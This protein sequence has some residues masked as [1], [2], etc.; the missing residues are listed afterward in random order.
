MNGMPE[1]SDSPVDWKSRLQIHGVLWKRSTAQTKWMRRFF[2]VRD[3]WLFYYPETEKKDILRRSFFNTSPKAAIPLGLC[4][5]NAC[6]E[7]GQHST[8]EV[9]S[10]EVEGRLVLGAENDFEREKWI[11]VLEKSKRIT[12]DNQEL[13]DDMIRS[14]EEQGLAMAKQKQDYFDRLQS[15]VLELADEKEKTWELARLNEELEKEKAKME[16]FA[17]EMKDDFERVKNELE[18]MQTYMKALDTERSELRQQLNS[19]ET[20][21]K[22]LAK[23][24]ESIMVTLK[25][26]ETVTQKKQETEEELRHKLEEIEKQTETLLQ[27]KAEAEMRLQENEQRAQELEEEKSMF[28]EQAQEL[29]STIKDLTVQKEMTEAE[30]KEE[31]MA[32]MEAEKR[33]RDAES[34]L[35]KLGHA[36]EHETPHIQTEVKEQMVVNVNKLKQFFENLAQEAK[37]DPDKPVIIKNSINAR[38]TIMRR[39]KTRRFERRKSSSVRVKSANIDQTQ[40]RFSSTCNPRRAKS[41]FVRTSS[42]NSDETEDKTALTTLQPVTGFISERF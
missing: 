14:L 41:T 31:I 37:I 13:S 19:Q 12:W 34:S 25:Q 26:Q 28:N 18:E 27:E 39:N 16:K 24:K 40:M 32:R 4:S 8:F 42:Q 9:T 1:Y 2:L 20:D 38:K 36:V 21:L 6:T 11:N 29:Q 5:I 3:G 10:P 23:E 33:L 30:L 15:E 35:S 22:A 17:E 7:Q